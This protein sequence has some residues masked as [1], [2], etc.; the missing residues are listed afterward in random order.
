MS[1]TPLTRGRRGLQGS[2]AIT[3]PVYG[4]QVYAAPTPAR[5]TVVQYAHGRYELRGDGIATA[6]QWLWI[7][8][9]T[10]PPPPRPGLRSNTQSARE[11]ASVVATGCRSAAIRPPLRP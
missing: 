1:R 8:N 3:P 7:P 4:R 9:P 5:P 6:Y 10:I 11:P 2:S